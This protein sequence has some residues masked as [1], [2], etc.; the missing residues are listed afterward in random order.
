MRK[1]YK[2][3]RVPP[4]HPLRTNN[5]TG[6]VQAH[7]V[8][9]FDAIGPGE[10][11]CHWCNRPL[12]WMKGRHPDAICVDHLDSNRRNNDPTNLV[13]SCNQCNRVRA[14]KI[15]DGELF[16]VKP[17]GKRERAE[18][19]DCQQCGKRFL[20]FVYKRKNSTGANCSWACRGRAVAA[21]AVRRRATKSPAA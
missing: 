10:H 5:K 19:A 6:H 17:T 7:R 11:P 2:T 12:Q 13:P 15:P 4:D 16:I 20:R 9:L 8:A 3:V 1:S 14:F 21:A 18:W